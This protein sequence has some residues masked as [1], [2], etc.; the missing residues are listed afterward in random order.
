MSQPVVKPQFPVPPAQYEQRYLAEIVRAFSV[1]IEQIQN[2][3][4]QRATQITLTNLQSNDV[5]LENGALFQ[6]DGTVKITQANLPHVAGSTSAGSVG[7]VTVT[8]S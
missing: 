5:G 8:I 3:G 4:L 2:P 6:V 1:F 7:D